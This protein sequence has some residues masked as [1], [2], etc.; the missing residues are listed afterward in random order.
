MMKLISIE[1]A[2]EELKQGNMLVLVDDEDRENEGDIIFAATFSTTELVNFAITHAKGVLCTPVSKEIA[3][4]LNLEPMVP[5]NTSLHETAFTIT[6]DAVETKTGVS[7]TERNLT[8][9]KMVEPTSNGNDFVRPGHIFP[10]I[11]KDG[12]VLVRTGHTEGCVDLCKLAGLEEI[13]ICCEIVKD[14]GEMARR[15][16]LEIFCDKFG[17]KMIAVSDIVRYRLQNES[18]ITLAQKTKTKI[19]GFDALKFEFIDHNQNHHEAFVFGE[20]SK[21]TPVKF[22]CVMQDNEFLISPKYNDFMKSLSFLNEKGGILVMMN[23][24]K[25]S[26]SQMKDYGIGAQILKF[27][28]VSEIELLSSN[29]NL[30]F[31]GISGFG[32]NVIK[33][34]TF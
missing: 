19:A 15:D 6:I 20:I 16:D 2:I 24:G 26:K 1:E 32:L 27:L 34:T 13:A 8:I 4:K 21:I 28:G 7:A 11:A 23:N 5:N 18:L 31:V 3:K 10:L 12:G 9:K 25:Q 30:E 14:D 33:T 22:H 29:A 17:L